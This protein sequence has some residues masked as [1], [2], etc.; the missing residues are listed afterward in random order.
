MNEV[1]ISLKGAATARKY[2]EKE[3][4]QNNMKGSK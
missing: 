1:V 3:L 4:F 2:E